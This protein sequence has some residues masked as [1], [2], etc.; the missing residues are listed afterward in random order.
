M[1]MGIPGLQAHAVG[2]PLAEGKHRPP[3]YVPGAMHRRMIGLGDQ[4]QGFIAQRHTVQPGQGQ[5]PIHQGSV[6]TTAEQAFEQFTAGRRL[7][8]QVHRRISLVIARQQC[9]Q[10]N[11]GSAV[12]GAKGK[13]P[14]RLPALHCRES[15]IAKRQHAPGVIE[16]YL[17]CGRQLQTLTLAAKQL[18]AQLL[19]QLTQAC[20]QVRRYPV[21][22][23][24]GPG[25]R[26]F[27][28]DR[29]EDA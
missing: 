27:L 16:Q 3:G 21:Q 10:V 4:H 8:L 18:D 17:A 9:R 20:R 6:Q 2:T 15:F 28:G 11:G 7:H 24:G 23:L 13:V 1:V 22:A 29:L 5:W 25:D 14:R 19:F 26:A 12:H